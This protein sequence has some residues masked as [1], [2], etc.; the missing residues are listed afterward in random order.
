M[1]VKQLIAGDLG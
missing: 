1:L